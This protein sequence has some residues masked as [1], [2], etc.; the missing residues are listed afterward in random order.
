MGALRWLVFAGLAVAALVGGAV[1]WA[2]RSWRAAV[3]ALDEEVVAGGEPTTRLTT[4]SVPVAVARYLARSVPG[5]IP[6]V[7]TARLRQEGTFQMAEGEEGWR[8]FTAEE[9]FRVNPPAFYWD[10]RIA[11]APGIAAFVR[12][13]YF[14]GSARMVGKVAAWITVVDGSDSPEL[15]T[16]ALARYL[17]ESVWFPTRLA[18]GPGLSWSAVDDHSAVA[19]MT[20]G[21]VSVS[22]TFT[23]DERG[24]PVRVEGARQ[25]ATESGFVETPWVGTFSE[26]AEVSGFRIPLYGE[27]GWVIDGELVPYWRGRIQTVEYQ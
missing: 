11:V 22:L 10:A 4:D 8:P 26:H 18:V 12:D 24:D 21:D 16:G 13:S 19:T 27:V 15:A 14:S 5:T 20:D 23:F 1:F 25:R 2:Q 6:D 7:G 17:A 9:V 3:E